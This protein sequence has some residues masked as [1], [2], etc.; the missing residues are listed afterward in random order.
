MKNAFWRYV[1]GPRN[2][3]RGFE[4][5]A[6]LSSA[7]SPAPLGEMKSSRLKSTNDVL[8]SVNPL[9]DEPWDFSEWSAVPKLTKKGENM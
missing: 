7:S 5:D 9:S 8:R 4:V 3:R 2:A 1:V 6:G